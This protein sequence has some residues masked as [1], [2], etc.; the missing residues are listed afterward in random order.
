MFQRSIEVP[1]ANGQMVRLMVTD[2]S[3]AAVRAAFAQIHRIDLPVTH[4]VNVSHGGYGMYSRY[5]ICQHKYAGGDCES[6]GGGYMEA[7][8]MRDPPDGHWPFVLYEWNT[9]AGGS[10][11]E[12]DSVETLLAAWERIWRADGRQFSKAKGFRRSVRCGFLQPWFYAV[13]DEHL[14]G[15]Y[16]CPQHLDDDPVFRLGQRCVVFDQD[17]RASIKTCLGTARTKEY[18]REGFGYWYHSGKEPSCRIVHFDDGTIWDERV[19]TRFPPRPL[20]DDEQWIDAAFGEF[21][22]LLSGQKRS[23]KIRLHDGHEVRVTLRLNPGAFAKEGKYSAI[24]RLEGDKKPREGVVPFK[25]TAEVSTVQDE[26]RRHF[27][28]TGKKVLSIRITRFNDEPIY[29]GVLRKEGQPID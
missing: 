16:A 1:T 7:L 4:R 14:V 17:G 27:H 28:S 9:S 10:F 12:F 21:R 15:D 22:S 6:G 3:E 19:S 13:G 5:D 20:R 18:K 23:G 2:E 26:I 8:E 29:D 24:V 11:S 25:P